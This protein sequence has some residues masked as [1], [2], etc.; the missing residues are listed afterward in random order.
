MYNISTWFKYGDDSN[1]RQIYFLIYLF[2]C[3][4]IILLLLFDVLQS[5][6][7]IPF[8]LF[9]FF[10][11]CMVFAIPTHWSDQI[12]SAPACQNGK[13][14]QTKLHPALLQLKYWTG[15]VLCACSSQEAF[16]CFSG[17]KL[18][19]NVATKETRHSLMDSFTISQK[20]YF[21]DTNDINFV[22]LWKTA[23]C[24]AS[25]TPSAINGIRRRWSFNHWALTCATTSFLNWVFSCPLFVYYTQATRF[26]A[27]TAI[28]FHVSGNAHPF[29]TASHQHRLI[30]KKQR[31]V[32]TAGPPPWR[33]ILRFPTSK[34]VSPIWGFTRTALWLW[35]ASPSVAEDASV[36]TKL[37]QYQT[38]VAPSTSGP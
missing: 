36:C 27:A 9:C 11:C 2:H 25:I 4:L 20:I 14:L 29:D 1:R 18:R 10:S 16:G 23:P 15:A 6:I 38:P 32:A 37:H 17:L 21:C 13:C 8:Y 5:Q 30:D 35:V 31:T 22:N 24:F 19:K 34:L 26:G 3:L 12:S 28:P 7:L 33:T